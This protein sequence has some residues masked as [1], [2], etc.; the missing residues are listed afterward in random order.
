MLGTSMSA[1]PRPRRPTLPLAPSVGPAV[2]P[3]L[4]QVLG[5]PRPHRRA[6][7]S[8]RQ[9]LWRRPLW[10]PRRR[11]GWRRTDRRRRTFRSTHTVRSPTPVPPRR[12][13]C[14]PHRG[15]SIAA[16]AGVWPATPASRRSWSPPII[17]IGWVSAGGRSPCRPPAT[18]SSDRRA[19]GSR[20]RSVEFIHLRMD[21]PPSR[22]WPSDVGLLAV[23][24]RVRLR[25]VQPRSHGSWHA[26][27][28]SFSRAGCAGSFAGVAHQCANGIARGCGCR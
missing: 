10:Q 13:P 11:R 2:G 9:P 27:S 15:T 6:R 26:L 16:A 8:R 4:E 28:L 17:P 18:G 3:V 12:R 23:F 25:R 20:P 5:A 14:P 7:P 22:Q 19:R 1:S 21:W 24:P